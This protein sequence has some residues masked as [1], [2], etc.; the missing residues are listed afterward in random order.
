MFFNVIIFPFNLIIKDSLML[1]DVENCGIQKDS[2]HSAAFKN[3]RI[4]QKSGI[5][6]K[7]I[8]AIHRRPKKL[9]F[10]KNPAED[11]LRFSFSRISGIQWKLRGQGGRLLE[12][13]KAKTK[14][15]FTDYVLLNFV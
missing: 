3:F 12:K 4:Q 13:D 9:A 10:S 2:L 8:P 6:W 11:S 14:K 1:K 7:R 15:R 5:Q